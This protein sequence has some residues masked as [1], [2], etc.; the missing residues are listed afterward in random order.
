MA[1]P[2][3]IVTLRL[4]KTSTRPRRT[5]RSETST[6]IRDRMRYPLLFSGETYEIADGRTN[7][8][9]HPGRSEPSLFECDT[10]VC[11]RNA[12]E[13]GSDERPHHGFSLRAHTP[14]ILSRVVH[15]LWQTIYADS[16]Q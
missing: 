10:K 4:S 1:Q 11:S 2:E 15:N 7:C 9:A 14:R 5:V 3:G 16:S 6:A 13:E 12:A 8:D